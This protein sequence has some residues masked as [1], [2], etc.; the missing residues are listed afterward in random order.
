MGKYSKYNIPLRS[1]EDGKHEFTYQLTDEYFKLLGEDTDIKKGSL[2]VV[3]SL[4]KTA[5]TFELNFVIA[6]KVKVPCDRCLDEMIM[7]VDTKSRLI[8]KFGNEYSEESDEIVI[9]PEED[10][11]INISWF[12]YEFIALSLPMKKVHP[13]GE[14][15]K[16][17]TSKL[18]RHKT[19]SSDEDGDDNDDEMDLDDDSGE[20][21][22]DSRWDAL[23]D[24][25]FEE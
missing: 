3:V 12:L 6:G 1:L 18:K 23:K 7:D 21:S 24:L 20:A 5:T 25:Q 8:V 10:G 2:D 13:Q 14:C 9:I 15:N 22:S 4:K 19:S 16:T 11:Q 17:M